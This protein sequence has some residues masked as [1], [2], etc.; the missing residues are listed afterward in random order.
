MN[1]ES[2]FFRSIFVQIVILDLYT[3]ISLPIICQ[4][5]VFDKIIMASFNKRNLIFCRK[6]LSPPPPPVVH[7]LEDRSDSADEDED[8]SSS[9]S[10]SSRT[11][12]DSEDEQDVRVGEDNDEEDDVESQ[13]CV[14]LLLFKA[15][16]YQS[17]SNILSMDKRDQTC[18][19]KTYKL[20]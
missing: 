3:D 8:E 20:Q 17:H 2:F 6:C 7:R 9:S 11:S 14:L 10:G 15:F 4:S 5:F 1:A 16:L 19:S 12:S 13:V 18:R